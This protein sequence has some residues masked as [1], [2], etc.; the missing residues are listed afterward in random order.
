LYLALKALICSR[1]NLEPLEHSLV[2][3][4]N[5]KTIFTSDQHWLYPLFELEDYLKQ[6]RIS[7]ESLFVRDKIAGKAAACLIAFLGIKR[8]HIELLSERAIPV[9]NANGIEFTFDHL[10]D[11]IQCRT[12]DLITDKMS[13]SEAYLFLRKRAGR[14]QGLPV[15]IENLSVHLEAKTILN[16]LN[17]DLGRGEQIIIHGAN[18]TGKTTLLRAML[19]FIT[20]TEGT[21]KIGDYYIGSDS[22]K[23]NRSLIGYV[24][25]EN[26]K[27][28]FPISA[29]E[30]VQIGLGNLRIPKTETD[31]RVE[32]AMRRTGS[33]HLVNQIYHTL[34]GGEKQR[35][36]L[37]R[38]LCQNARVFLM[39]E[40]TSFLDQQGKVDLL[41]L[42]HELSNN[43][44]PTMI[45]VSHELQWIEQLNWPRKELTGGILC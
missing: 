32:V 35:V 29:G 16:H 26:I 21:I 43:E 33:F 31:Y 5:D 44:A 15:K 6:S 42:L 13:I 4:L 34:S 40:P 9:L 3:N 24:H 25:Q 1:N 12:E 8:C 2:V 17:F 38:C 36:S 20:P 22:W 11:H 10:V 18:G 41:Q 28:N 23:Q 7:G 27:N 30:V 45:I 37:A 19:G 39:D 14:V